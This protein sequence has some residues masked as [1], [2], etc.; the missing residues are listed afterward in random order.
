VFEP[1][2]LSAIKPVLDDFKFANFH[3]RKRY[4]NRFVPVLGEQPRKV[5]FGLLAKCSYVKFGGRL[6]KANTE[7]DC[8]TV[9]VN[10]RCTS[11][12]QLTIKALEYWSSSRFAHPLMWRPRIV[13]GGC[14]RVWALP[15]ARDECSGRYRIRNHVVVGE[16]KP[17]A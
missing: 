2:W 3:G 11:G 16:S 14:E 4:L 5:V 8:G 10:G 13:M 9:P 17:C 12:Y 15:C 6:F 7:S 1:A